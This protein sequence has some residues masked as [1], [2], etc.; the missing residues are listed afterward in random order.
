MS[1]FSVAMTATE[2]ARLGPNEVAFILMVHESSNPI[3]GYEQHLM[4]HLL[5]GLEASSFRRFRSVW[6]GDPED[7][8]KVTDMLEEE[9]YLHRSFQCTMQRVNAGEGV[10][11]AWIVMHR[12]TENR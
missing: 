1:I 10:T 4:Q 5:P 7:F 11:A 2:I 6:G 9:G 8:A 3:E 12:A